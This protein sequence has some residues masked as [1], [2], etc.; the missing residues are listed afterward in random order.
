MF[1][2]AHGPLEIQAQARNSAQCLDPGLRSLSSVQ[3]FS[4]VQLIATPWTAARQVSLSITNSQS[5]LKLMSV[6][7]VMPSSH[8]IL[9]HLVLLLPSV[10]PSIRV[11]SRVSSSYQVAK[12]LELP[13]QH[14][15]FQ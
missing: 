3:S 6:E 11:F 2:P 9:Y 10:S 14:Q 7:S 4:H 1:F 15:S 12:V 8:L 5:L 13:L